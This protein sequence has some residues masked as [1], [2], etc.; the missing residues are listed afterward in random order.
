M[1]NP[2][3]LRIRTSTTFLSKLRHAAHTR[4][5]TYT[6]TLARARACAHVHLHLHSRTHARTLTHART[7]KTCFPE[8]SVSRE[9]TV[10]TGILKLEGWPII[11]VGYLG[12]KSMKLKN[13]KEF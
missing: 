5:H 9:N 11:E 10:I 3:D 8:P 4:T 7:R 6:H 2:Q 1:Y 12:C 13:P